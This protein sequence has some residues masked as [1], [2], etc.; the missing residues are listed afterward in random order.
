MGALWFLTWRTLVN[1]TR[2][3]LRHPVR[4]VV[5]A[6]V[7]GWFGFIMVSNLVFAI[8]ARLRDAPH[9]PP[10]LTLISMDSLIALIM[11][12]HLT[13]LWQPLSPW[14][15][16]ASV[17]LFTPADVNFLFPSPQ[18]RPV[19]FFFLLFTRGMATSLIN[20]LIL[21]L[22]V[23]AVGHDLI[24]NA[25]TGR[26]PSSIGLSWVY[27]L[28]YLL[29][30][31]GL[32]F[33]GMYI[34]LREQMREGF[35]RRTAAVFWC[36]AGVLAG[37]LGAYGYHAWRAGYEPLQEV[38][39]HVLH[40]PMVAI[41]L[42]PL[43]ALAE[44][45]LVFY[46][47]WTPVVTAGFLLWGGFATCMVWLLI[48]EQGWLYDLAAKMSSLSTVYNLRRQSPAQAAYENVVAYTASLGSDAPRWRLFERWTPQGVWALLWCNSLLLWR[49]AKGMMLSYSLL[50]SMAVLAL[51][52]FLRRYEPETYPLLGVS[53]LYLTAFF[54]LFF[55][56]ILLM[57]AV[58]RAEVNKSL[59]FRA[60]HILWMEILPPSLLIWFYT[61]LV[62]GAFCILLPQQWEML[63]AH[64]LRVLSI[65]PLWHAGMLLVYL[66]LPDQSDYTQRVLLGI[67]LLPMLL[68]T[69]LPALGTWALAAR[70]DLPTV[71]ATG[72]MM[73]VNAL[74][75][76]MVVGVAASRYT[77]MNPVE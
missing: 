74:A 2:R 49:M 21:I 25:L 22:L 64:Y 15:G 40:N 69:T 32:L 35:R 14:T 31:T 55:T 8:G 5:F 73:V 19:V 16:I 71:V 41:P 7:V 67:L 26:H 20:L 1:S 45:A 75:T 46:K 48:R 10:D 27:P 17:P 29:A 52:V 66:L 59:P 54:E 9:L 38:V 23:L 28:M 51:I 11:A 13:M 36:A 57:I 6:L 24:V 77:Q 33:A 12:V 4:A 47:G 34:S 58:R 53:V 56:Q 18:K 39:W 62:W 60:N 76:W 65:V 72:L 37:M 61:T 44:A 50:L 42:L 68:L 63:T 3:T 70:L 30:F 43:R